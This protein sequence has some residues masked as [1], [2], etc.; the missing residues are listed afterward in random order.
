MFILFVWA[1]KISFAASH[2]E[3]EKKKEGAGKTS[4][5][6]RGRSGKVM[7]LGRGLGQPLLLQATP[8]PLLPME[9]WGRT[10]TSWLWRR[11]DILNI[12]S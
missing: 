11:G 4:A 5:A 10:V 1:Q 8:S 6:V 9:P 2:V 12:I 7:E 3:M